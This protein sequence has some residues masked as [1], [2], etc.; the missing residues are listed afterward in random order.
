MTKRE[1]AW[2]VAESVSIADYVERLDHDVGRC[3]SLSRSDM[4]VPDVY[5]PEAIAKYCA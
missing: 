1:L 3:T 5:I 4:E 2:V